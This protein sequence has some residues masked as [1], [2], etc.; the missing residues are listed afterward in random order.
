MFGKTEVTLCVCVS[1][2]VE[3]AT[4]SKCVHLFVANWGLAHSDNQPPAILRL[5]GK[6]VPIISKLWVLALPRAK[7][8]PSSRED[9]SCLSVLGVGHP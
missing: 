7:Q 6:G 9:G 2:C 8:P 1:T 5:E 3:A 4:P